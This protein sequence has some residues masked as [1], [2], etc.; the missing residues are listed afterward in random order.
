MPSRDYFSKTMMNNLI[1]K[2]QIKQ[3][4]QMGLSAL[5]LLAFSGC[6]QPT[7][8]NLETFETFADWCINK[9][10]LTPETRLT[11]DLLLGQT[12]NYGKTKDCLKAESAIGNS[13]FIRSD[14]TRYMGFLWKQKITDL[15]PIGSLSNLTSVVIGDDYDY[16]DHNNGI[17]D[18]S[19]LS[20]LSKLTT[21]EL[22]N[23]EISDISPLSE[24][25]ELRNS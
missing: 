9:K 22:Y 18:I 12:K 23:N 11:V 17:T 15:S 14:D 3:L 1:K 4:A 20:K 13:V 6:R 16:A 8:V 19:P 5:L 7:T 24:L 2:K 10:K 25:K 21:I